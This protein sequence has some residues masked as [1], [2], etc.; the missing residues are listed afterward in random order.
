MGPARSIP[1]DIRSAASVI[2]AAG[3][4]GPAGPQGPMG[5]T[6]P[7]GPQGPQ[8]P[9][10]PEGAAGVDGISIAATQELPGTNCPNGGQKLTPLYLNGNAAGPSAHVC[11]GVAGAQGPTGA[12]GATGPAGPTGSLP[13]GALLFL[14]DGDQAPSG[15]LRIGSYREERVDPDGPKGQKPN[16]LRIVIWRKQ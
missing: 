15:F 10:G 16:A 1:V 14:L 9:Q 5:P 2:G 11:N 7:E 8:G 13:S 12:T 6:G 4:A 3:S